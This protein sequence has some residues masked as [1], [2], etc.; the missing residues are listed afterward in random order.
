[1]VTKDDEQRDE[2]SEAGCSLSRLSGIAVRVQSGL[3]AVAVKVVDERYRA[4]VA[5]GR[6]EGGGRFLD[7]LVRRV[8]AEKRYGI[9]AGFDG[10][11]LEARQGWH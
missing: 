11:R 7:S 10:G 1:M 4:E 6:C 5:S 2:R 8:E 9:R 3:C